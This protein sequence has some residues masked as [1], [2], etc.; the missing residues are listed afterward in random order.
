MSHTL[1]MEN[2]WPP[3]QIEGTKDKQHGDFACNIALVLAKPL[4]R[5]PREIAELIIQSLRVLNKGN[6]EPVKI[7]GLFKFSNI[8]DN[9]EAV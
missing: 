6:C 2:E 9:A 8:K 3:I 1:G 4:K 7:T 5:K